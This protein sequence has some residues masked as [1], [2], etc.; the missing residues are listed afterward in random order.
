MFM[1]SIQTQPLHLHHAMH[2]DAATVNGKLLAPL[3]K[4]VPALVRF[5]LVDLPLILFFHQASSLSSMPSRQ[6]AIRLE[7]HSASN[8]PSVGINANTIKRWRLQRTRKHLGFLSNKLWRRLGLGSQTT[9]SEVLYRRLGWWNLL[10]PW[11][12]RRL[13]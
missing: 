4:L 10:D 2:V 9:I 8:K 13:Y 7:F 12:M 5:P 11:C 3:G 6:S 1:R